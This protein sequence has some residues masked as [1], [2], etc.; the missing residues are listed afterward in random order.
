MEIMKNI[1]WGYHYD[2]NTGKM[3]FD[4]KSNIN[5]NVRETSSYK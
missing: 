1:I 2:S 4:I 5:G 3:T